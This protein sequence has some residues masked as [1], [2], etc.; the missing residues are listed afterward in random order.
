MYWLITRVTAITSGIPSGMTLESNPYSVGRFMLVTVNVIPMLVFF[1]LLSRLVERH[2]TTDFGRIFV[3][4]A[5]RE[6]AAHRTGDGRKRQDP[7]PGPPRCPVISRPSLA[8]R[9]ASGC[10]PPGGPRAG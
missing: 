8:M 2:G 6:C 10:G 4:G 7:H 5:S 3:M 1:W 9:A